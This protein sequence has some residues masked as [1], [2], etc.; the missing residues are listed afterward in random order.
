[1]YQDSFE[2]EYLQGLVEQGA[3]D[4]LEAFQSRAAM[5]QVDF[6][7]LLDQSQLAGEGRLARIACLSRTREVAQRLLEELEE[8]SCAV[9]LEWLPDEAMASPGG[10]EPSVPAAA[11]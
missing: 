3:R 7:N 9:Q 4:L 8:L 2:R 6:G 10:P 11:R 1:M 5:V